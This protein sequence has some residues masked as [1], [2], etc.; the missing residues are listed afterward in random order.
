MQFDEKVHLASVGGGFLRTPYLTSTQDPALDLGDG[1]CPVLAPQIVHIPA[2]G[3]KSG[4]NLHDP[5]FRRA[6]FTS[7]LC[8]RLT[9]DLAAQAN[10]EAAGITFGFSDSPDRN[11]AQVRLSEGLT[12]AREKIL[13]L[14]D[15]GIHEGRPIDLNAVLAE[16]MT[17]GFLA[18]VS[19]YWQDL[20]HVDSDLLLTHHI[21]LQFDC[22]FDTIPLSPL[23][24]RVLMPIIGNVG[25]VRVYNP[26]IGPSYNDPQGIPI[27]DKGLMTTRPDGVGGWLLD[28]NIIPNGEQ[29]LPV[30]IIDESGQVFSRNIM[31][32]DGFPAGSIVKMP[33]G[34][35]G[36]PYYC[37]LPCPNM[38]C[39]NLL[40]DCLA[41]SPNPLRLPEG[42]HLSLDGSAVEG[43]PTEY[44]TNFGI[45]YG[46]IIVEGFQ[47]LGINLTINRPPR[48]LLTISDT[49]TNDR[50][51]GEYYSVQFMPFGSILAY[52]GHAYE[53]RRF[54]HNS[55]P[56]PGVIES[57]YLYG[58]PSRQ[59]A[60]EQEQVWKA[61][62]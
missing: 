54:Q 61:V 28:I 25:A 37:T 44:G 24:F 8:K 19:R 9:R 30:A 21:P 39:S 57:A 47:H 55:Q 42:L 52:G 49:L 11:I 40:A 23:P 17:T 15:A 13:L 7:S 16:N 59:S 34:K 5:T 33:H 20:R 38:A 35:V 3:R 50:S 26:L 58:T 14:D 22:D 32:Q 46:S 1:Q 48:T 6:V 27:G 36:I 41:G 43:I 4:L 2:A 12:M 18:F 53:F 31:I 60:K 10:Q 56:W 45:E 62:S 29:V 51:T